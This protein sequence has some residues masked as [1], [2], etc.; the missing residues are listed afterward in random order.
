MVATT[1]TYTIHHDRLIPSGIDDQFEILHRTGCEIAC[2][3]RGAAGG[4]LIAGAIGPLIGAYIPT[5]LPEDAVQRFNE[6]CRIQAPYV[7]HFL[8]ETVS[9]TEQFRATLAD[10]S[11]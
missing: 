11:D 2:T 3:T 7:D 8:I 9:S 1:N 10:V 5:P 6:I 4:G